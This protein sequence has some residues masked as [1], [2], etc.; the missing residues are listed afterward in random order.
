MIQEVGEFEDPV[1]GKFV[2][3]AAWSASEAVWSWF[4]E[5]GI[6]PGSRAWPRDMEAEL[7]EP[8]LCHGSSDLE[9][10]IVIE[11]YEGF[12]NI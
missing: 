9:H 8:K 3:N 7:E 1:P 4:G 11:Y 5:R 2:V 10:F 6:S 12:E